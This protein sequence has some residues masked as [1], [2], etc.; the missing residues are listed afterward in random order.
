MY[1]HTHYRFPVCSP[2]EGG[3]LQSSP[4]PSAQTDITNVG[5]RVAL[6][7][8]VGEA[9]GETSESEL[10]EREVRGEENKLEADEERGDCN[11]CFI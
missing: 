8:A 3:A 10:L 1:I 7:R 6:D 4:L 5:R 11:L 9:P 2:P